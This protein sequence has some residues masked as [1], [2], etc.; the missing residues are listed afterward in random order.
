MSAQEKERQWPAV[1]L[2][3]DDAQSASWTDGEDCEI[4]VPDQQVRE[5][6]AAVYEQ[7]RQELAEELA[8]EFEKRS[9]QA[10]ASAE[11]HYG[12]ER[13]VPEGEAAGLWI[14]AQLCRAIGERG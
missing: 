12:D 10:K 9:R 3:W 13:D 6:Q 4:Y 2:D 14:A 1:K 11:G 7:A 5:E 8:A